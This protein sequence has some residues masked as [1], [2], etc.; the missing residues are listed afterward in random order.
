ME[1]QLLAIDGEW[2]ENVVDF[3]SKGVEANELLS[4]LQSH[5]G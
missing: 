1:E 3:W 5:N 2:W 4:Y